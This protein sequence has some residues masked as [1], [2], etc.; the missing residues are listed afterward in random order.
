MPYLPIFFHHNRLKRILI[1]GGGKVAVAKIET[2]LSCD[3][4]VHVIALEIDDAI[5]EYAQKYPDKVH[6]TK[7]HYHSEQLNEY[8][9]IV[10]ATNNTEL[11]KEIAYDAH[12]KQKFVNVVDN[13]A[14][15]DF[16]F[17][18]LVKRG[19]LQIAISSS[20]VSPVLARLIKQKIEQLLPWNFEKVIEF[21]AEKR[22]FVKKTLQNLQARRLFWEKILVAPFIEEIAEGNIKRA[23]SL[24]KEALIETKDIKQAALYLISAGPGHPDFITVRGVH[25]LS[26][27]DIILYDRLVSPVLLT[28]YARKDAIKIFVGK[29]RTVHNKTQHDIDAMIEDYLKKGHIV[30]RLKGGDTSFYAHT[31]EEIA[32][33]RKLN[34]PYQIVAGVTAASGCAAVAGIPLTQ[35]NGAQTVRILTLNETLLRDENFWASIALTPNETFVFYM[36]LHYRTDMIQKLIKVGLPKETRILAIEQGTTPHHREYESTLENFL[37]DYKDYDFISPTL[38]IIGDVIAWRKHYSWKEAE[39]PRLSFFQT[40]T[41]EDYVASF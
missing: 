15:C 34:V 25:L 13:L 23:D 26:Q 3:M 30:A 6:Y 38:F 36:S 17:P 37:I 1:I 21:I 31:T 9:I 40:L 10:V 5:I 35:R 28:Q 22:D 32:V 11:Q 39:E 2:L 19:A 18:A 24:F 12:Q 16:I 4:C 27:A 33:A 20:G 8:R 14:L 41:K 29:T 7:T